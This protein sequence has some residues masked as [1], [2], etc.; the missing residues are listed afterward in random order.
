MSTF[1]MITHLASNTIFIA[2]SFVAR[3]FQGSAAVAIQVTVFSIAANFYPSKRDLMIGMLEATAGLGMML[4][5]L[6]GTGLYAIGGYNFTFYSFGGIFLI[7]VAIF[8]FV[9]PKYLDLYTDNEE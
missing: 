5:P 4:G 6:L 2:I 7:V 1:A 8:P 3:F 9:L